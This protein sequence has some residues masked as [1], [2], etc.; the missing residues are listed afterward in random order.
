MSNIFSPIIIK[1]CVLKNRI[2]MSPMC[3]YSA[4]EDGRPNE[5]HYQHWNT[6][7]IGQ[8]GLIMSEATAIR[9]D[10]M[11]TKNDLGLY[12][13]KQIKSFK[14]GI[15]QVHD[16][17]SKFGIQL[18]HCG[19]KSWGRTK[20]FGKFNLK[21]P[22]PIAFDKDWKE[23]QELKE[24]EINNIINDF[25]ASSE[26]AKTAG[27][28]LVEIHAAHGYLIHQ[29]LSP[30][31]NNRDDEYGGSTENRSRFLIEIIKKTR[32]AMGKNFPI[33]VRLSCTDWAKKGGF[34]LNQALI[35]SKLAKQAG[36]DLIDCSS[37]GTL[38]ITHPPLR[39]GYQLRFATEIKNKVNIMT[40]GV[41]LLKNSKFID[42]YISKNK[43]DL[44]FLGRE[45]LSNPYWSLKAAKELNH[46]KIIPSQ[47][48]RG[49]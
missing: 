32:L 44:A 36:A 29:F 9:P 27:A 12:N 4:A 16:I 6:R 21:A 8:V 41:G 17:G 10:G 46:D 26:R 35:T 45:L 40:A 20:G 38:P 3:Q 37:G 39:E 18:V 48:V 22:S 24:F 31:S 14:H 33:F 30:L 47:Y 11:L 28:D 13:K 1:S 42:K 43:I 25:V 7:A 23:P 19:R 15:E 5:W 34:N 2:V 49:F